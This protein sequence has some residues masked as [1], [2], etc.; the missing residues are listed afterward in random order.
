MS[1]VTKRASVGDVRE[2]LVA[3]GVLC[4]DN[5]SPVEAEMKVGAFVPLLQAEFAHGPHSRSAATD[6]RRLEAECAASW[7]DPAV[8]RRKLDAC[9]A[10]PRLHRLLHAAVSRWAP[11]HLDLVPDPPPEPGR[12]SVADLGPVFQPL[13]PRYLTA[14]QLDAVNPLPD[15]RKRDA[16]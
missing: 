14:A 1:A 13:G 5:L 9:I 7:D 15:G 10:D 4:A 2:W 8:I 11:Q 12:A 3:L 16:G 6:R